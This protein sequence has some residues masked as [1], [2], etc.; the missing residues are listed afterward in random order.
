MR[1]VSRRSISST[2]TFSVAASMSASTGRAPQW[3]IMFNVATKVIGVVTTSSPGAIPSAS[4]ATCSPAVAEET[5]T[6]CRPPT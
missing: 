3:T 5:G 4:R 2:R 1:G 6:A